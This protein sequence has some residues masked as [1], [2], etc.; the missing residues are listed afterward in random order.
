[1]VNVNNLEK[2]YNEIEVWTK[3]LHPNITRI[4]EMID[5][6][7]HDYLFIIMELA[8]LGQL[9]HWNMQEKK[10]IRV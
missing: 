8:E 5:A 4:Y 1:M 3:C 9:A 2:V 6:D 10:Y 7:D